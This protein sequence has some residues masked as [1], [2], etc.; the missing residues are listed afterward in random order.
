[1]REVKIPSDSMLNKLIR[2]EQWDDVDPKTGA[3][4]KYMVYIFQ[5]NRWNEHAKLTFHKGPLVQTDPLVPVQPVSGL[6]IEALLTICIDRLRGFQSKD[7]ACRE[8]ALA[9][10]H[11]E[12]A[13]HWLEH[14]ARE[15][16]DRG[17][18]GQQVK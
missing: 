8:N 11:L 3:C 15:R 4:S 9:I 5:N 1:M 7:F 13:I 17:V 2:V 14:R 10:T 16:R 6:S 12:D 18:E